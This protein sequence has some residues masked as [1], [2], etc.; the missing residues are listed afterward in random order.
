[1]LKTELIFPMGSCARKKRSNTFPT[2]DPKQFYLKPKF[3]SNF[4][5]HQ[6][7]IS[8]KPTHVRES[9]MTLIFSIPQSEII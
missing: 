1:M 9:A 4:Q 7:L 2:K 3:T 6:L 5:N 8:V